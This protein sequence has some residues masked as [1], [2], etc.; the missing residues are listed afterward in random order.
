MTR[1]HE[2][3]FSATLE[4]RMNLLRI[5]TRGR[6]V[7]WFPT[8]RGHYY[9][10]EGFGLTG[11]VADDV[12]AG[13]MQ[14]VCV[15]SVDSESFAAAHLPPV[16]R[17]ARHDRY[18]RY[19]TDEVVPWINERTGSTENLATMGASFGAYHAVNF[20]FRHPDLVD[21]VVGLSGVYDIR[22]QLDGY[23]DDT[24]YFHSPSSYVSNMGVDWRDRLAGIDICI[25]SG[26]HD[27]LVDRTREFIA[28]LEATDIPHRGHVWDAPA[29]HDWEWW[30]RQVGQYLP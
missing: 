19:L 9:D 8:F 15:D 11:A 12:K 24:A 23:W 6:P 27:Y 21:K 18:D 10:A 4:R 17:L 22:D 29:G 14:L 20:G 2:H 30:H 7:L 26:E 3:W 13:R 16:D 1:E 28:V 25:V 5:G